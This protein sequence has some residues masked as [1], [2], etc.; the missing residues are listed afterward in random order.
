M[1]ENGRNGGRSYGYEPDEDDDEY[2]TY[3]AT[4][5]DDEGRRKPLMILAVVALIVVFSGVVFLAYRQGI[6]QGAQGTPPVIRADD[7]PV[8]V[9]PANPGG[10]EIPHQ[11]K[12]VYDRISG[13]PLAK[14]DGEADVERL[15]PRAEEPMAVTPPSTPAPAPVNPPAAEAAPSAAPAPA[16]APVQAAPVLQTPPVEAAPAQAAP[17]EA[18]PPAPQAAA[19]AAS[20]SGGYVVQIAAFRDEAS[21]QAEFR[22]LQRKFPDALGGLSA[23]IQRADL[24]TKGIYY[25]LRVGYLDK[26]G[27]DRV[28]AELKAKGQGCFVRAR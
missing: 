25:R 27:A 14:S 17:V 19:P 22:K 26:S 6:K 20:R 3:D 28:C 18:A 2:Y 11:D 23:D 16:G 24:G 15:L 10:I 12:S 9:A 8:K 21:A 7:T 4:D 1:S 13:N 5:E